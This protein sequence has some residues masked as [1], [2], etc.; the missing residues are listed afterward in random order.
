MVASVTYFLNLGHQHYTRELNGIDPRLEEKYQTALTVSVP[1]PFY[2]YLN[3]VAMP[4]PY[5]YEPTLPLSSLLVP[6]PQYGPLFTI[7]E[8]AALEHYNQIQVQVQRPFSRGLNFLFGYVYTRESQQINTYNDSTYYLNQM[9]W[10]D[11]NQPRHRMNL[12]GTYELP[13]GR[14]HRFGSSMPKAAD[15]V[16]GGWRLTP[17]LQY[18]SGDFPRFGNMI[19]AGNPCIS[20]PTPTHWFNTAV[21]Q[22]QPA[23]TYVL[24]SNPLQYTCLTGP[25]FVDLDASLAKEFPIFERF[26]GQ[27]KMTAYNALNNLN[28]GDPD[29]GVTSST[30]GEA[31]YQGS[32]GGT[33]GAQGAYEYVSGRQLELGFKIFW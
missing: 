18:I 15:Y 8:S 16:L 25:H 31:L 28:R 27:L 24:Q 32:P 2:H 3:T 9:Q 6:Y 10:Q 7:G 33:F 29:T 20:N 13:F 21:F 12:A 1:N 4:G 11:S 19:A 14:A 5:Y 17:V 30:F 23:N 22:P 26:K